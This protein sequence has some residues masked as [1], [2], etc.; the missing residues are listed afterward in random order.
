MT[1]GIA[2]AEPADVGPIG[3]DGIEFPCKLRE[4]GHVRNVL[5]HECV[6]VIAQNICQRG[7]EPVF[8]ADFDG[9][10]SISRQLGKKGKQDVQEMFLAWELPAVK[11][12]KLKNHRA[13]LGAEDVHGG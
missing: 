2:I 6:L 12:G 3:G 4:G 13:E 8:V 11:N 7:V 1:E 5:E 10:L 9:E